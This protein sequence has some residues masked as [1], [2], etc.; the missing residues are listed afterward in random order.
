MAEGKRAVRVGVIGCGEVAQGRH[1]PALQ[2]L[3]GA[4]IVALADTDARKLETVG[5]RFRIGRRYADY[6]ALLEDEDVDAVAVCVPVRLHAE[7]ATN[8]MEAGKHVFVEKPL[9]LSLDECEHL[10]QWASDTAKKTML[11][12]NLRW[13]R[14]VRQARAMI[15]QGDL[16]PIRLL[17]STF[18][19]GTRY[20]P[21]ASE[22]KKHRELGGGVLIEIASHHFDLW[23]FLLGCEVEEISAMSQPEEWDDETGTVTARMA[24]GVLVAS[25]FSES[26]GGDHELCI[27][28]KEALL[29][30]SCYRFD[31]LEL[32]HSSRFVGDL[33]ARFLR[34]LE[35]ARELPGHFL[36]RRDGGDFFASYAAEWRHFIDCIQHDRDPGCTF[37]DGLRAAQIVMAA[38]ASAS[39]GRAVKV[40]EAPRAVTPRGGD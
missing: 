4:E 14:L 2:Q 37:E 16:G 20:W 22:W 28:G 38:L 40:A 6:R 32:L 35:T 19:S 11:G 30:V 18:T 24:N 15:R 5:E 13:H 8:A 7:L 3:P 39:A 1:L 25:V 29:R 21:N 9:A 27:Y 31:G 17:R 23:R 10:V 34:V 36:R 12:F 33:R 26:T